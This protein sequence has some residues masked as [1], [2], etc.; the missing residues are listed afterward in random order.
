VKE[1]YSENSSSQN[2]PTLHN[3]HDAVKGRNYLGGTNMSYGWNATILWQMN[4]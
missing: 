3:G 2:M 1:E 4:L